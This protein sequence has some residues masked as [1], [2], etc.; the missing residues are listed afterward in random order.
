M[1]ANHIKEI[2]LLS[3]IAKP[4]YG[5][6]TNIGKAHLKGLEID[7]VIKAKGELYETLNLTIIKYFK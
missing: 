7:G 1:G 5:I 4:N 6:I 2:S 3:N